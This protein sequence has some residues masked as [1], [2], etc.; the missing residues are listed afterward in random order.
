MS[1]SSGLWALAVACVAAL[2]LSAALHPAPT[3]RRADSAHAGAMAPGPDRRAASAP[4][5]GAPRAPRSRAAAAAVPSYP[6]QFRVGALYYGGPAPRHHCTASVV[7]SPRRDVVVTAAHC[8]PRGTPGPRGL[9]FVPGLRAGGLTAAGRWPVRTAV[10]TPSWEAGTDPSVDVA[11][12]VLETV[13]GR[14]VQDVVGGNP[15]AFGHAAGGPVQLIGY[16]TGVDTPV[17][18]DGQARRSG[19]DQLRVYCPGFAGGTSGSP[20]LSADEG[21]VTGTGSG[22]VIGVIGGYEGGGLTPEVSYSSYF[23]ARVRALYERAV[24]VS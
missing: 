9:T 4:A 22:A 2:P 20:W 14:R 10:V 8:V 1:R 12:L 23:D 16:P 5:A 13:A 11:F 19:L 7:D 3:A 21:A 18:C 15:I 6:A 17:V 24:A